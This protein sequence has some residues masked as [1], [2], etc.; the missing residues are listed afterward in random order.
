[1]SSIFNDESFKRIQRLAPDANATILMCRNH[2]CTKNYTKYTT[3]YVSR[4]DWLLRLSCKVCKND[5]AVCVECPKFKTM[6]KHE[7]QICMHRNT[8]HKCN[9]HSI[10]QASH[11][12]SDNEKL[13]VNNMIRNGN[14]DDIVLVD[15]I[16]II[17]DTPV[18]DLVAGNSIMVKTKPNMVNVTS[19]MVIT[20]NLLKYNNN[21]VTIPQNMV[22]QT[23]ELVDETSTENVTK[24]K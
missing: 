19:D 4:H 2:V 20:E 1:M 13:V 12:D 5:W 10:V 3:K 23:P 14:E 9:R 21:M 17:N 15:N 6:M 18:N 24:K 16:N 7:R 22:T 8:Y 11:I